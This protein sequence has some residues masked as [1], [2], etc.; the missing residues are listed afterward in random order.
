MNMEMCFK[1]SGGRLE[2]LDLEKEFVDTME[3]ESLLFLALEVRMKDLGMVCDGGLRDVNF[4]E[5]MCEKGTRS[6]ATRVSGAPYLLEVRR[7]P[8]CSMSL[9][10]VPEEHIALGIILEKPIALER[11]L[12]THFA[13]LEMSL[14]KRFHG[15]LEMI[16]VD[17]LPKKEPTKTMIGLEMEV[18]D[19][20]AL[21]RLR[22]GMRMEDEIR[23]SP[24]ELC[25]ERCVR[26]R[27]LHI[28]WPRGRHRGFRKT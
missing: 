17:D 13:A 4:V 18:V 19:L 2:K 12:E 22:L 1:A 28:C 26:S 14:E 25:R 20:K 10:I 21:L 16:M 15:L 8:W 11:N 5:K 3:G 27:H 6:L 7:W 9:E 23:E 24:E